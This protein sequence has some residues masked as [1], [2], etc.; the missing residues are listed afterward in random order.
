MQ[1]QDQAGTELFNG[2]IPP[3]VNTEETKTEAVETKK[4]AAPIYLGGKKFNNVEE[5]AAYTSKLEQ[6]SLSRVYAT[7]AQETLATQAKEKPI[8]ELIFED[9]EKA[10]QIH[11]KR[12]IQKLKA[13][14]ENK[15]KETEFWG[16]FY[17]ENKDL[18]EESDLVQFTLNK[19][20]SELSTLHP[21]QASQKIADYT[22]K[23]LLRYRGQQENKQ[24]LPSG[25][26]KV[27]PS[28]TATAPAVTESRAA[29]VDFVSQLK[30]IQ[31]S[32]K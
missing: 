21:D 20:W 24:E 15:R 9:P 30:K 1:Q 2:A 29:P 18:Q 17:K 11:E 16:N 14:E 7:P 10:L 6:E 13:E 28:S 23:T 8:S 32:R 27:G 22:R 31:R 25:K 5:L 4:E 3:A 26:A 19:H 12:V